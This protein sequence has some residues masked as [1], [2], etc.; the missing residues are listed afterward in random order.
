MENGVAKILNLF[1]FQ[2]VIFYLVLVVGI[3]SREREI[4][5]FNGVNCCGN[6]DI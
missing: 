3:Y 2:K 1:L 4:R 6:D 5:W